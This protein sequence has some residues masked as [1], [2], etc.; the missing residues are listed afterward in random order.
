M[1]SHREG[2]RNTPLVVGVAVVVVALVVA[3]VVLLLNLP[4]DEAPAEATS[5]PETTTEEPVA[6][7]PA[8]VADPLPFV[9]PGDVPSAVILHDATNDPEDARSFALVRLDGVPA[10]EEAQQ[11][12]VDQAVTVYEQGRS[13]GEDNEVN[14]GSDLVLATADAVGVQLE[15]TL[16]TGGAHRRESFESVYVL[17]DG[18]TVWSEELIA[19]GDLLAGWVADALA[20]AALY[21]GPVDAEYV[22]NDLRFGSDGTVTLMIDPGV[23]VAPA[24][25]PVTVHVSPE[26]ADQVLSDVGATLRD[27]AVAAEPFEPPAEPLTPPSAA[28][29]GDVDCS[30]VACVALTFDDGPGPYTAQLLDELADKDVRATFFVIGRGAAASPELIARQIAEGHVVGN[31]TW[32]HPDLRNLIEDEIA[33]ELARTDE[34]VVAAG[35]PATTLVRPPYGAVNDAVLAALAGHGSPAILWDV[36]TEDWKNRDVDVTTQRALDG[37][38][39]GAIILMHDIHPSTVEAIP[40]IIDGLREAGYTL[41]TVPELLGETSPG[42]KYFGR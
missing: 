12:V 23:I 16:Y 22:L 37:A 26:S 24:A 8:V 10:L 33:S 36:D 13:E 14:V 9:D 42:E 15:T 19:E 7:V 1:A 40:G 3:G 39:D 11:A 29:G 20:E 21:D 18:T 28:P 5:S 6:A 31:H 34:A 2:G 41:V 27:A 38:H 35:A 4:G 32:S 25:G 17:A 30:A